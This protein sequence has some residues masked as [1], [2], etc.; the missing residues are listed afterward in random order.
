MYEVAIGLEIHAQLLTNTKLF[1][2]CNNEFGGEA[3]SKVCPVCAG[4]PGAIGVLNKKALYLAA[5]SGMVTDCSISNYCA[6]DRK[7]YF[8][9]DLPKAYQI[10]Q[11]R[12]PVCKDGFIEVD[13]RIIRIDNIHL[14]EDAGKLMHSGRVSL[15]DYNRCGVP[16]V[17]I[18]TEPDI[19]SAHEA[20]R[21]VEEL[22]LRLKYA[23]ICDCKMEEGSLRVDVNISLSQPG[24]NKLGERAEI[25][26]LASLKSVKKTIQYEIK[27]QSK[28]LSEGGS[29][30]CETRRFDEDLSVT[31]PMRRK[32]QRDDYK[33]F[34]EPDITPVYLTDEEIQ[35]IKYSLPERPD[36]RYKRYIEEYGLSKEEAGII[37]AAPEI[38]EYYD[39]VCL[40]CQCYKKLA[41][42]IVVG[43][44]RLLNE[45]GGD[46]HA[47]RFAQQELSSLAL[48]WQEEQVSAAGAM[49]ILELLFAN[50]GTCIQ[51]AQKN[52]L[53]ISFDEK[54]AESVI[55][56]VL[57]AN[58][59]AISD[60]KAGKSKAFGFLMGKA[61]AKLGKNTNPAKV[62]S[63][64]EKKLQT[65]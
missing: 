40:S 51:H 50:G 30:V 19:K 45:H 28:I 23:G 22:S 63:I 34:P 41:S 43:L 32:E 58:L 38:S 65:Y 48:M 62:K 36:R 17:E 11:Q 64:L 47:L 49:E 20:V 44:G 59:S 57:Q 1:C 7:N 52:N 16:L 9:P 27:R 5:A 61:V 53:L 54:E 8:Y 33:Y 12:F 26:N 56:G 10:T 15:I 25:K 46:F 13:G 60:Y 39:R 18:V 21:F 3:N 29:I 42:L 4:F 31:V 14:E 6:F 37:V 2:G 35:N 24:S 55:D